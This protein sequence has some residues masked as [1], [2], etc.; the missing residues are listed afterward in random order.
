[1]QAGTTYLSSIAGASCS[2]DITKLCYE[3]V[4]MV[5]FFALQVWRTMLEGALLEARAGNA[6]TA[7]TVFRYVVIL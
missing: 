7:R 3:D 4:I 2:L 1:M 5:M 6:Q